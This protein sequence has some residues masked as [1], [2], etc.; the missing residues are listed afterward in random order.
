MEYWFENPTLK[1]ILSMAY[2][3]KSIRGLTTIFNTPKIFFGFKVFPEGPWLGPEV[4]DSLVVR[5]PKKRAF[6]VTDEYGERFAKTVVQFLQNGGFTT[7]VWSGALP[8]APLDSVRACAKVM[9]DFEPDLI[10]AVGG[11]S[12]MD[13]AKVAWLMY[14]R[15]DLAD[16]IEIVSPLDKLNLRKK[17][18]L[19]AVPTTAGTGSECTYAAVVH[20]TEN[21]RKAPLAHDELVP[22]FAILNPEFTTSMPPGLT[23]GTGLDVLSHA[24]DAVTAPAANDFTDP[25]ALRAIEMVFEWLPKA[26]RN[27]DDRE[28]RMKMMIAACLSGAAFGMSACHVTHVLGHSLGA[29]FNIHHGLSVGIF[30]PQSLQFCSTVTDKHLLICKALEIGGATTRDKL[31]NLV[32]RVRDLLT[33]LD[34]PLALKDHGISMDEFEGKMGAL[35]EN[36]FGDPT[37]YMAPRPVTKDQCERIYRYAYEG[38]DIDF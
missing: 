27:G 10:M 34:V 5:C 4:M 24:V 26:Y 35:V 31:D 12:P 21:N 37:N 22:D 19:A 30:V 25:Y 3:S 8:E 23:V 6:L 33:E 20:D 14:E 28:A 1:A 32:R 16:T 2:G 7:E 38:K 15:P 18:V 29:A 36:A 9:T 13:T 17:A 11:G